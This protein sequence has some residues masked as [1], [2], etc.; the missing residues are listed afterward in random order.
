MRS[1]RTLPL[2]LALAT[3][4][5]ASDGVLEIN[6]TCVVQT[7]CFAG[8][9]AGFPVTITTPGSDRLTS[10]LTVPDENTVGISVGTHDAGI[11]LNHFATLGPVTYSGIPLVCTP[12]TQGSVSALSTARPS[13]WNV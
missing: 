7:G 4:A 6:Q 2:F 9:T 8:D 12:R 1:L 11:D 10:D 5:I 13:S 3:P